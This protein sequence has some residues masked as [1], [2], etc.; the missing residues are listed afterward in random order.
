MNILPFHEFCE[1]VLRLHLT[2]GQGV[3][4]K[5]AFGNSNPCDLSGEEYDLALTMFGGVDRVSPSA[6]RYVCLR[7]GRGSG[8]TTMCSAYS[9]YLAVTADLRKCG[10]GD[11]PYVITIA[12]DKPTAQLSIR[13]CREMIR[14]QPALER[15]VTADD[16]TSITIRRPEGRLVKIE[17]FAATRGG[18]AVRG[19]SIIGFLLDEAEFFTS[20]SDGNRDYSVNDRDIF[21]ALKPRLLPGGKGMMVSTPW[22]VETLMGQMFE[23]N[24]GKPTTALAIR[25]PT[26]LVRGND[27]DI[28]A[29]VEDEIARDPDNARRELFCELD[30]IG[31]G[32]FFDTHALQLALD[33][34][35]EFPQPFNPRWPVA[36]GCD[37]GF[38]RDS[39]ALVV[40][41]FDGEYYRTVFIDE[42]RPAANKPLSPKTVIS[43][44]SAI[45]KSY[46]VSGV[47]A[48][49]YY[50]ESIK[51]GLSESNLSIWDAPMG[52]GGK[53]DVFHRTRSVLHE[54][55]I[56]IPDVPL[57]R[58]LLQQAKLVTSKPS[59]GGTTTIKIPR[60]IGLGHGDIVSAWV[61]AVHRLAYAR[62]KKDR[63]AFEPG[64]PEWH[65]EFSKRLL[66]REDKA[67]AEYERRLSRDAGKHMSSS[68]KR[69]R[70]GGQ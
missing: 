63:P 10:V 66:T 16:T 56:K 2:P 52:A 31:S 23:D 58:R 20:N 41:Q 25:A 43:K 22:P 15:L 69:L 36:V 67:W 19:R 61:L 47:I 27:P 37:F 35:Y 42:L 62:V 29:M 55:R 30:H 32:E 48:D 21:Q 6:K 26:I 68:L 57:G 8:K 9:V 17:A 64:S 7:L 40:V 11:T 4:A 60:K 38:T 33:E 34:V 65:A 51:E 70:F 18:S 13:M 49:G 1:R 24:W 28:R 54:G 5:V 39:S 12:P 45:A 53:A 3:I 50:R 46:G 44:F 59:P 14:G